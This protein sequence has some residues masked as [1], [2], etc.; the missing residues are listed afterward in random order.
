MYNYFNIDLAIVLVFIIEAVNVY[1]NHELYTE[2]T[3]FSYI[4]SYITKKPILHFLIT[5]DAENLS[6]D[7]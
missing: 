6:Q 2:F 5:L 4:V 3:P 7:T 1:T